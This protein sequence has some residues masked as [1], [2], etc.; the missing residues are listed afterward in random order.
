VDSVSFFAAD[1]NANLEEWQVSQISTVETAKAAITQA[2]AE[3]VEHTVTFLDNSDDDQPGMP[4]K[5]VSYDQNG[6]VESVSFFANQTWS[7]NE[8]WMIGQIT[9]VETTDAAITGPAP[10]S[11]YTVTTLNNSDINRPPSHCVMRKIMNSAAFVGAMPIS[12]TVLYWA[13][14]SSV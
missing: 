1:Y 9:T 13:M 10:D 7:A 5:Q 14:I 3:A 8:E 4:V 6:Q 2:A 12:Q 11:D